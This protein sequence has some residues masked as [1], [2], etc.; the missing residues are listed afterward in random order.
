MIAALAWAAVATGFS[1]VVLSRVRSWRRTEWQ[2]SKSLVVLRPVEAPSP[3]ELEALATPLPSWVRQIVISPEKP[4]LPF[5]WL[6]SDPTSPNRK[7]GHLAN[8]L[9]TLTSPSVVVVA[10]ADVR[11]TSELLTALRV[12]I[13]NGADLCTAAP[14]PTGDASLG[15]LLWTAVLSH[16]HLAF[17]ALDAVAIGPKPV[18]GKVMALSPRAQAVLVGLGH[19]VG[20]DLELSARLHAAGAK[21]TLAPLP[22]AACVE[23][24]ASL[25]SVL[26]RLDRW[27][28]VLRTQRPALAPTVPLLF[29][30]AWPVLALGLWL[31]GPMLAAAAALWLVRTALAVRL[32]PRWS[33]LAWPLAELALAVAFFRSLPRTTV[34]WRGRTLAV[35]RGGE[36][37]S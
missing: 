4:S 17:R 13:S 28:V 33:A 10:D 34:T 27:M 16:G 5:E 37:A 7:V 24:T 32:R 3:V 31:R 36:I 20:E 30:A 12:E 8:A 11:L 9:A 18:C 23:P 19:Y 22:A 21:V 2:P 35:G 15:G 29:C 1:L 25:A 14:E 6:H 26:D